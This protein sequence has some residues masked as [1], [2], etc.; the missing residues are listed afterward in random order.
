[1][2]AWCCLQ[3]SCAVVHIE[4]QHSTLNL[5]GG[6]FM[7]LAA[8]CAHRENKTPWQTV[9]CG[10]RALAAAAICVAANECLL[11]QPPPP[12]NPPPQKKT[13]T[14]PVANAQSLK[15]AS[16]KDALAAVPYLSTLSAALTA[17]NLTAAVGPDFKGVVFA[18]Q[19]QAFANLT[20]LLGLASPSDLL[21]PERADLLTKVLKYHV[22]PSVTAAPPSWK[23]GDK[24]ATALGDGE[25]V[26][27]DKTFVP[28]LTHVVGGSPLNV[29]TVLGYQD[30]KGGA[31]VVVIDQVLLPAG[32]INS[33]AKLVAVLQPALG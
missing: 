19:D 2:R 3:V 4:L 23:T 24:F 22:A 11:T 33:D 21:A 31:R 26:T 10:A 7:W 29:A 25:A 16:V 1:M 14:A 27:V 17:A 28:G 15:A 32:V 30:V 12:P 8:A 6:V 9:F 20:K 13:A 18:P 5:N